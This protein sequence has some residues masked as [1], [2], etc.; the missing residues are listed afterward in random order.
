MALTKDHKNLKLVNS[1]VTG[2]ESIRKRNVCIVHPGTC[3]ST[4]KW[5]E[6]GT[7]MK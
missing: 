7:T 3:P 1:S 5:V 6:F 4:G 2:K